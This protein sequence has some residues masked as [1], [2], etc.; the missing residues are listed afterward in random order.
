M[1][2]EK[3]LEVANQIV[4]AKVRRRLSPVEVAILSGSWQ[5]QTYEEIA[6]H[7][8]YAASYLKRHAGPRLWQLLSDALGEAV[9][10]TNFRASL[11]YRYQQGSEEVRKEEV[12]EPENKENG[13]REGEYKEDSFISPFID[14]GEALDVSHFYGRT[15]ELNILQQWVLQ[16]H[17]RLIG[18]L[19]M[20]GIGKTALSVKL[21]EQIQDQFTY[22]IWRSLR[23]APPIET[24]LSDL[25]PFLSSD[26]VPCLSNQQ[27]TK[28]ELSQLLNCLRHS[29]CLIIL[30]NLE[31]VLDAKQVG[32]FRSGFEAYGDLL[33]SVAEVGHQSCVVLTSRE[34]LAEIAVLEGDE[35][36]VRSTKLEGSPEAAQSIIEDKGL[37]GTTEQKEILGDRYSNSP[38]ALKIVSTS[39]QELFDSNIGNFLQEDTLVFSGIRRLLEQQFSRL[40]ALEQ[41]IMY[42]LAIN[43]EWTGIAELQADIVPSVSKNRLLEALEALRFRCL[44]E[45]QGTGFTQQPV[46]MEYITEQLLDTAAC[47]IEQQTLQVLI[48]HAL[49]K[50]EAVDY[51]CDSQRQLI[52]E[53]LVARLMTQF[54]TRDAIAHHLQQL[55]RQCQ[56]AITELA[57]YGA[58]NLL[59]LLS[60]LKADLTGNDL[61]GLMLRQVHLADT[62][63]HQVN[64]SNANL[65]R[66]VFAESFTDI[67]GMGVSPD[68]SL[69]AMT[70]LIGSLYLYNLNTGQWL[71]AWTAHRGWS[72]SGGIFTANCQTLFT[73]GL[74]C[75]IVQWDVVTGQ[76]L[77]EW[78][79][80]CPIWGLALSPNEQ[81][82]ASGHENGTVR[83]WNL[84]TKQQFNVLPDQIGVVRGLAFHPQTCHLAT[85]CGD[86]T[87]KLWDCVSG[88]CLATFTGHTDAIWSVSFNAQGTYLASASSD[89]STKLW[90]SK[91]GECLHTFQSGSLQTYKVQ[92]SPDDRLLAC[93]SHDSV[94]S[95]WDVATG[96]LI[97]TLQGHHGGVW[98]LAFSHQGK[99]LI[100]GGEA[101]QVKIWQV[102]SGRC[103]KTLQGKTLSHHSI[104]FNAQG[105][106]FAS[107]GDDAQLRLWSA[108]LG[109][110]L[111]TYAR[112][113]T[114][115]M[116]IAFHPDRECI[117][118]GGY[119]GLVKLW[120][121]E[122][123]CIHTLKGHE[124]SV[125]GVAFH[126]T[127]PLLASCGFSS[128][129]RFWCL[130]TGNLVCTLAMPEGARCMH[131]IAFHPQGQIFASSSEDGVVRLWDDSSKT[132]VR[133]LPAHLA[134]AWSLAFN[135]QG[136]LLASG[137]H[138]GAIRLWEVSSG[139][140]VATFSEFS[141]V[142]M[143]VSFSPDG[144]LL[145]AG[146]DRSIYIWDVTT[147][148]CLKKLEGHHNVV[149]SVAFHPTDYSTLISASYDETIRL[150]NVGTGECLKTLRP[151]RIYEGMNIHGVT[152]LS[153]GQ[154]AV[155]KQLGAVE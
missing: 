121:L 33:R 31:T 88:E 56:S 69:L 18:I 152:G 47:E 63:L 86:G 9:S 43:R 106:L 20:G 55:L 129:I 54:G 21:A 37:I 110:C 154:K 38:L 19:G 113:G 3:G 40:S 23:N 102:E 148:N 77:Y 22:V 94:I 10:K 27:E 74:D 70:G 139:Q 128:V 30:D 44:I 105:T 68:G 153:G 108:D 150:W 51:I 12:R 50:A 2:V 49:L 151:D 79:T 72:F 103:I 109:K 84:L 15:T 93:A 64:L 57:D 125:F 5:G 115:I 85:G 35:A 120:D 13:R 11:E 76:C 95:L 118:T 104:Q 101:A 122:G 25:V 65:D 91:T 41:S 117:A 16:D 138:D 155:L 1:D 32:Q 4:L 145:A 17:C 62:P 14:W 131:E 98:T 52:L 8:S 149:S 112:H 126:P 60:H 123:H 87:V 119:E 92:F 147:G 36:A 53:P 61:S 48:T 97:R 80:D 100:S 58:G 133:A 26:L 45:Q 140:C 111:Q 107:G 34:K 136:D 66:I 83:L 71:N 130:E 82:L 124:N 24:L 42:W 137:G 134:R 78:Q 73:A 96:R 28:L 114:R 127:Q 81:W 116:T 135:P 99:T 90:N 132:V 46:V 141:G 142:P 7:T 67:L 143:S 39:I 89:H 144:R 6:N 146:C 75:R 29:R 59:N